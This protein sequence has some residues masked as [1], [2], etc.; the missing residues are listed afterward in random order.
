MDGKNDK[1]ISIDN[2]LS[3]LSPTMGL[4]IVFQF[5]NFFLLFLLEKTK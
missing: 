3:L 1:N 4:K 5:Y 2:A